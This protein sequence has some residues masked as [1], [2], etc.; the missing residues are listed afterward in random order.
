M[1]L[2]TRW[3][4]PIKHLCSGVCNSVLRRLS[5]L[6]T[7][8]GRQ[9]TSDSAYLYGKGVMQRYQLVTN[10]VLGLFIALCY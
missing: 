3:Q 5:R 10:C 9:M 4:E 7:K 8:T 2:K 6:K 1:I